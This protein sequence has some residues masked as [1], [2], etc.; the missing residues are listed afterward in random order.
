MDHDQTFKNLILDY[1][2]QALALFAAAEAA[3]MDGSA[4]IVTV[5]QE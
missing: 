1:P 5:R 3:A 2:A 4:R